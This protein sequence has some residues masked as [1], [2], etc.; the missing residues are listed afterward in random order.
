MIGFCFSVLAGSIR[1]VHVCDK[2][3]GGGSIGETGKQIKPVSLLP[4]KT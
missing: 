4:E 2:E 1:K 3:N